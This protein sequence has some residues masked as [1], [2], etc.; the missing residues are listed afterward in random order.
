[1]ESNNSNSKWKKLNLGRRNFL[2]IAPVGAAAA[3][4]GVAMTPGEML[5]FGKVE[6]D[7]KPVVNEGLKEHDEFPYEIRDD[8][9][10]HPSYSSV[11]GHAFFGKAL[12]VIGVDVDEE[13]VE[14]GQR[15]MDGN[16]YHFDPN[17]KGFDQKAKAVMSGAWALCNT[18]SGPMPGHV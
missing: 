8:Y 3:G 13:A 5:G 2:K 16:N 7:F 12:R 4:I 9:R 14:Q 6:K 11:H 17:K 10:P 1:M 18:G 15:F